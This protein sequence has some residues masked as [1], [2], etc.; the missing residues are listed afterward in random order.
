MPSS[1]D[2]RVDRFAR[3]WE[4]LPNP[5]SIDRDASIL[6]DSGGLLRR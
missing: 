6:A 3:Q 2:G 5:N 4:L 1:L